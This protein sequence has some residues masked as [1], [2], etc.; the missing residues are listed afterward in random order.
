MQGFFRDQTNETDTLA[1]DLAIFEVTPAVTRSATQKQK[2]KVVQK[3]TR[4]E[5]VK[6][7]LSTR[8]EHR[9]LN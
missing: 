4:V 7:R 2:E 3:R 8:K 5:P 9:Q 6:T 1:G